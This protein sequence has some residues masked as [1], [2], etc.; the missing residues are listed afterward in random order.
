MSER[1]FPP[2]A[3]LCDDHDDAQ[4]LEPMFGS[5][6]G[7]DRFCGPVRTVQCFEDNS[8]VS[9]AVK[10]PGDGAV[11]VVEGGGSVR[12][13]L[14]GGNVATWAHDNGWAGIVIHGAIRDLEE[15]EAVPIGVLALGPIPRKSTK[16]GEG[17]RDLPVSF[18][19][20]AFQPGQWLYAD[21]DGVVVTDRRV[22]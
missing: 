3:D 10:E 15:I 21:E 13:A 11:L 2:T 12:R 5:F 14:C 18:G 1:T 6:G 22:H 7:V 17:Q 4:V 8:R 16:R 20:V 9:E 19:G